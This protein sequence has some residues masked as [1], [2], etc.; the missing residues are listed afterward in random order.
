MY[1]TLDL[2]SISACPAWLKPHKASHT[3]IPISF[4]SEPTMK[5]DF[6]LLLF[7]NSLKQQLHKSSVGLTIILHFSDQKFSRHKR[8]NCLPRQKL[9]VLL[10]TRQLLYILF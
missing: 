6:D 5:Y 2:S 7:E 8:I 1:N 3:F 9:P 4:W 10:E